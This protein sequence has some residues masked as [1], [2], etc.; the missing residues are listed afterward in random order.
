[1]T[2]VSVSRLRV[3]IN[4]VQVHPVNTVQV[5]RANTVQSCQV[6]FS[7]AHLTADRQCCVAH[8]SSRS[9][10]SLGRRVWRVTSPSGSVCVCV[11]ARNDVII[12]SGRAH[13]A[14]CDWAAPGDDGASCCRSHR[15]TVAAAAAVVGRPCEVAAPHHHRPSVGL[16]NEKHT[17][18][19]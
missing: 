13:P 9:K 4:L 2:C 15:A 1:M 16:P 17:S 3:P 14:A 11:H 10:Q 5:H 6:A 12:S 19:G 7:N 18:S 8:T